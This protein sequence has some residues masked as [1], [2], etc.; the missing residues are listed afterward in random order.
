MAKN[1]RN[2]STAEALREC[3]KNKDRDLR[4]RCRG[5]VWAG[6]RAPRALWIPSRGNSCTSSS[7]L[8]TRLFN[9]LKAHSNSDPRS[10][11]LAHSRRQLSLP[12]PTLHFGEYMFYPTKPDETVPNDVLT[13]KLSL[14]HICNELPVLSHSTSL[15][16]AHRD[17]DQQDKTLNLNHH[18]HLP[19]TNSAQ[20]TPY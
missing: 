20:S 1:N 10:H 3:L 14:P 12:E 4:L 19:R 2:G 17:H 16:Q 9:T 18:A 5:R 8:T 15:L 13:R 6:K 11:T 7:S